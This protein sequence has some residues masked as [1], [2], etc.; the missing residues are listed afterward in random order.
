MGDE[1]YVLAVPLVI[2]QIGGTANQTA[3]VYSCSL[4]PQIIFGMLGGVLADRSRGIRMLRLCYA[5]SALVLL[6]AFA[7]FA[8]RGIDVV[9]LGAVAVLLGLTASAAA[10][11]FDRV[12]P[13]FVA[14]GHLSRA[15]AMTEASRTVCVV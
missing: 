7:A 4:F 9:S 10:A 6:T 13:H 1:F 14:V 15:N 3:W 11:C 12:L 8:V 2:L 5:V